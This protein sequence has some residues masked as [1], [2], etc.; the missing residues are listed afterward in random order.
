[1]RLED[2]LEDRLEGRVERRNWNNKFV[3]ELSF[4]WDSKTDLKE[5]IEIIN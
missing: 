4:N 5:E 3:F 2:R 1:M